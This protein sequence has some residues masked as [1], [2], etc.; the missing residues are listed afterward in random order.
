MQ[1][2][3]VSLKNQRTFFGV[4]NFGPGTVETSFMYGA[5]YQMWGNIPA[6]NLPLHDDDVPCAVC[7]VATPVAL[8]MLPGKYTCPPNCI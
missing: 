3:S 7:Y 4:T 6:V 8:L 2:I 5:E 1:T